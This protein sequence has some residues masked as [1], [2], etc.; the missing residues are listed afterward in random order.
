MTTN[1]K[2]NH[3]VRKVLSS[4]RQK[5]REC[6]ISDVGN[7]KCG[8]TINSINCSIM[9]IK[10]YNFDKDKINNNINQKNNSSYHRVIKT[11]NKCFSLLPNHFNNKVES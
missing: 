9:N 8:E 3:D 11:Q 7:I 6:K 4:K 10:N 1:R 2:L 5:Q